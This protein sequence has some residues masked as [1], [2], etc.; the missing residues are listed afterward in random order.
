MKMEPPPRAVQKAEMDIP[1][2]TYRLIPSKTAAKDAASFQMN[3][4]ESDIP[5]YVADRLAFASNSGPQLPLFLEKADCLTSYQ[6]LRRSSS[7]LPEI[8]NI[9]TTTLIDVLESMKK[10][11]RPGVSQ[12]AFYFSVED[13]ARKSVMQP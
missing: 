4:A 13:L 11:T 10:G 9:R 6:R 3:L 7:R 5:L 2:Q 1:S 8:P 12:L